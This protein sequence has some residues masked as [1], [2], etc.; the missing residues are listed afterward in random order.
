MNEAMHCVNHPDVETYLRCNKC[1]RPICT[2]CAVLTP[3][4][5]RCQDCVHTQQQVFYADFRPAHYLVAAAVALPLALVAGWLVPSLGWYAIILGP[6]TGAGIAEAARWAIRRRRGQYTWL[7]VCGCIVVGT[8]PW[9]LLS[10]LSLFWGGGL[11]N[12]LWY[13]VYLVT[14]VGAAYAR[15]RPGQRV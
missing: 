2:K 1:G 8:L 14:A 12:L 4:G 5:Y 7:V 9:L 10:L 15:L 3:V 6:L 13:V 11:V